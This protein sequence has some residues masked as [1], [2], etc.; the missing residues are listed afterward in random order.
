MLISYLALLIGCLVR[1]N[2]RNEELIRGSLA[3]LDSTPFV[4][5]IVAYLE[6]LPNGN[7]EEIVGILIGFTKFLTSVTKQSAPAKVPIYEVI[8]VLK[9]LDS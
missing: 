3:L 5:L 1:D 9:R 2:E 4:I 7:F 8:D 6:H